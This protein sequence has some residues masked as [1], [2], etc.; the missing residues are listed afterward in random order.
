MSTLVIVLRLVPLLAFAIPML[1][2]MSG[3]HRRPRTRPRVSGSRAPFAANVLTVGVYGASLLL[4]PGSTAGDTALF[5]AAS[6]A[7]VGVTG[8]IIVVRSRAALG[9]AWS[10]VAT[11]D[12]AIGLVTTGPYRFVRHPIYS[13]FVLLALGE[14]MS[15]GHWP[16][17]LI[18]LC[19]MVPTFVWR[20]RAEEALLARMFGERYDAYARRTRMLVPHLL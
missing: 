18:V 2:S 14:A 13:G 11:A 6:G 8:S 7:F 3:R 9:A 10:L 1:F 12:R 20:A 5:L 16:A 19:A 4:W 15:L 17:A